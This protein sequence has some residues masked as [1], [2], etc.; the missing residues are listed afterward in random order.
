MHVQC[1][2]QSFSVTALK[3]CGS[4]IGVFRGR[5]DDLEDDDDE[6]DEEETE[7]GKRNEGGYITWVT[8]SLLRRI[9]IEMREMRIVVR[10]TKARDSSR[11]LRV[12]VVGISMPSVGSRMGFTPVEGSML[13]SPMLGLSG[14]VGDWDDSSPTATPVDEQPPFCDGFDDSFDTENV[15]VRGDEVEDAPLDDNTAED[16]ETTSTG[17]ATSTETDGSSLHTPSESTSYDQAQVLSPT[18]PSLGGPD[19]DEYFSRKDASAAESSVVFDVPPLASSPPRRQVLTKQPSLSSQTSLSPSARPSL[20]LNVSPP[21]SPMSLSSS[22]PLAAYTALLGERVRLQ[23]ILMRLAS[24]HTLA[25]T[26]EKQVMDIL[27]LKSRKRAWSSRAFMGTASIQFV[28]LAIPARRSPLST[29]KPINAKQ[30]SEESSQ[31]ERE[32][33]EGFE[34]VRGKKRGLVVT[35]AESNIMRLFPVCEEDEDSGNEG[36]EDVVFLA[37]FDSSSSSGGGD[38][39]SGKEDGDAILSD[40]ED[41]LFAPLNLLPLERQPPKRCTVPVRPRTRT[42]S[43]RMSAGQVSSSGPLLPALVTMGLPSSTLLFSGPASY[44]GAYPSSYETFIPGPSRS[45]DNLL[46]VDGDA[47]KRGGMLEPQTKVELF[48]VYSGDED[49]ED[50]LASE[51]T[52]ALGLSSPCDSLQAAAS[53]DARKRRDHDS[54]GRFLA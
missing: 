13:S 36:L 30:L 11:N 43:M 37:S 53:S 17:T 26:D 28:A 4:T 29:A 39:S 45:I 20:S 12:N 6:L 21:Q 38:A 47:D 27:E 15:K 42:R 32:Y 8:R 2:S 18:T 19:R 51:F 24:Q 50:E 23:G 40:A 41:G 31:A 34:G 54:E 7:F 48:D 10:S 46:G 52:Q 16:D 5:F 1:V 49:E 14:V 22:L 35:T 3:S 9:E 33:V 25:Q 44:P